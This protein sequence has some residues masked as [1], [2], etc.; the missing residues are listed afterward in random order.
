MPI[1]GPG[2]VIQKSVPQ[3][4]PTQ[5]RMV[6]AWLT[7][8]YPKGAPIYKVFSHLH[9]IALDW[10]RRMCVQNSLNFE[11]E[12]LGFLLDWVFHWPL[13]LVPGTGEPGKAEEGSRD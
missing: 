11:M 4:A 12:S 1:T 8:F 10:M 9:L 2:L 5:T 6:G 3:A 7:Y 13:P